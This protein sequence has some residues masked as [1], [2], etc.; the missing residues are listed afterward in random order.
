MA[1]AGPLR[2]RSQDQRALGAPREQPCAEKGE[3]DPDLPRPTRASPP[4]GCTEK[5]RVPRPPGA[6]AHT[7][8]CGRPYCK[9]NPLIRSQGCRHRRAPRGAAAGV[10]SRPGLQP[11]RSSTW[12]RT[13]QTH[14]RGKTHCSGKGPAGLLPCQDQDW[15]HRG[16]TSLG[17]GA[18]G[19]PLH[20]ELLAILPVPSSTG[21]PAAGRALPTP[22]ARLGT[23]SA[24]RRAIQPGTSCLIVPAE[25]AATSSCAAIAAG[26]VRKR[27]R[28]GSQPVQGNGPEPNRG[29]AV[30]APMAM[31][32]GDLTPRIGPL[33]LNWRRQG[34]PSQAD[35][36][37]PNE[38]G[39]SPNKGD[40]SGRRSRV[41][42][43]SPSPGWVVD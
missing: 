12:A 7:R 26:G 17:L 1:W 36:R 24:W 38:S 6:R 35:P 27:P 4:S 11:T 18:T 8:V 34:R 29:N 33:L 40:G 21:R 9:P 10:L 31:A 20:A 15:A 22:C 2:C 19:S 37:G 3:R 25:R 32:L 30:S 16:P 23:A 28:A 42:L 13:L 41:A 5:P 43:H 39:P 14:T